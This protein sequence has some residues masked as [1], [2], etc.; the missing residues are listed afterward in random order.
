MAQAATLTVAM[1]ANV[2][3]AAKALV[4]AFEASHPGSCV[5]VILGSSGKLTA[6]IRNGAPYDLFLSADMGYPE[7]LYR[8]KIAVTKP[9]VYARGTLALFSPRPR[10]FSRG[11]AM[12]TSPDIRRIAVANPHTAPYGK[13]AV[14]A[15]RKSGIFERVQSKIVYAES[16]SQT[17]AYAMTA[18]DIGLIAKSSLFSEKMGRFKEGR[19][20]ITVDPALYTPID[21][22]IVILKRGAENGACRAFYDFLLGPKAGEIFKAYGYLLP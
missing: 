5:R 17:V 20:W 12:L 9:R 3:Y 21:Q 19:N 18:A 10:D 11:L 1:A 8:E 16:I 7:A 4:K 14:E 15:L 6:Q 13:A 2:S 22:G